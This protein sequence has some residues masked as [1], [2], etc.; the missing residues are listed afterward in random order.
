M[1][2]EIILIPPSKKDSEFKELVVKLRLNICKMFALKPLK[3]IEKETLIFG[4]NEEELNN[5][6]MNISKTTIYSFDEVKNR[7]LSYM[8]WD[9]KFNPDEFIK[10]IKRNESI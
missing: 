10:E 3:A 2:N 7:V 4:M 9:I 8:F 5:F 1:K 6:C